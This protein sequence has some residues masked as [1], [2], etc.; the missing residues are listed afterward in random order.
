MTE[1]RRK[2]VIVG[3]GACGK[4]CLLI[5]FSKVSTMCQGGPWPLPTLTHPSMKGL[6]LTRGQ[7]CLMP[8]LFRVLSPRYVGFERGALSGQYA[9]NMVIGLC[10]DCFRELRC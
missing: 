2:L 1:L 9:D 8:W 6:V 3:D 10:P 4:T 7:L 5:V